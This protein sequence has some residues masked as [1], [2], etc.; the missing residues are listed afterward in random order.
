MAIVTVVNN[1]GK[2]YITGL[3]AAQTFYMAWGTG[4]TGAAITNTTISTESSDESRVSTTNTQATTTTTND[5]LVMTATN[6]CAVGS[7]TITNF[8]VLTAS[9]SGTL[10]EQTTGYTDALAVGDAIAMTLKIQF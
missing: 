3:L 10:I 5:T 2:G 4:A 7:K 9:S 1:G 8:G 6:T